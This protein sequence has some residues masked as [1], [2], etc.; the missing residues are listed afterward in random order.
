M[1]SRVL[2]YAAVVSAI[3]AAITAAVARLEP[4]ARPP[5]QPL[6]G[7]GGAEYRHAGVVKSGHGTGDTQ[8]WLYEPA[9]P[10]P[11]SAPV[12]I[13][14]HGWSAMNPQA[15]GAW[16]EHIVRRGN[17]VIY[18]RYQADLRTQPASFAT[19]AISAVKAAFKLLEA[20]RGRVRPDT[21]RVAIVGHSAGGNTTANMA[22][23][24]GASGLPIP[25][26]IMC[27]EPG[28]SWVPQRIAIPLEDM[29]NIAPG[30]LLLAVVGED[31]GL[32][33]DIDA[34][35]IFKESI[36][37]PLANKNL[38]TLVTD[39]HGNP[40]LTASHHA[41][42][43]LDSRYDSGE[44]SALGSRTGLLARRRGTGNQPD[45]NAI[46]P[47]TVN[48]LDYY[49]VWKLFDGLCDA[50]F[51]GKNRQYALGNTPEQRFMGRWSD[52]VAVKEMIVTLRP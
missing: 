43:A 22:A 27:V 5:S 20:E 44:K 45:L 41:P 48:A 38:V 13:F 26:A 35:R 30:T 2:R 1:I 21:T 39:R 8:Y 11:D 34:K 15:Y 3:G 25:K 47:A 19:N 16:I 9:D 33:R 36:R 52:G 14:N 50:A 42:V 29:S 6:A 10:K 40:P 31:D 18:P 4:E 24:A 7:P 32:A 51:H 46:G 12:I 37:V 23:R 17:I 28:N 49:G